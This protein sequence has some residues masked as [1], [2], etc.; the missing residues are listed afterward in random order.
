MYHPGG[1][2]KFYIEGDFQIKMKPVTTFVFG[3]YLVDPNR[4][5]RGI[6]GGLS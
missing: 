3:D 1:Q 2:E 6:V 5:R 4:V